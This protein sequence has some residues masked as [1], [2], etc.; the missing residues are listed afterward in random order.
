MDG[1]K[2]IHELV[3]ELAK[4]LK[5]ARLPTTKTS[6]KTDLLNIN[7]PSEN[8]LG[9]CTS[10]IATPSCSTALQDDSALKYC[11]KNTIYHDYIDKPL[12]NVKSLENLHSTHDQLMLSNVNT[13]TIFTCNAQDS[14]LTTLRS[15]SQA[16]YDT[17]NQNPIRLEPDSLLNLLSDDT[18]IYPHS[19]IECPIQQNTLNQTN[20]DNASYQSV[21]LEGVMIR[22][23][24]YIQ[25]PAKYFPMIIGS[26]TY[27]L[28][29]NDNQKT[30]VLCLNVVL[31]AGKYI[32]AKVV[33]CGSFDPNTS[34]PEG[35]NLT[36]EDEIKVLQSD[37][38]I[39]NMTVDEKISIREL[40]V[41]SGDCCTRKITIISLS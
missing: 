12:S 32:V 21:S 2:G 41:G 33:G 27:V 40:E 34:Y 23:P 26:E 28:P 39:S 3:G 5:N 1:P 22:I 8:L 17:G 30:I 37:L 31:A 38:C 10:H 7:E 25:V 24:E 29:Y 15:H 36:F 20:N 11:D 14:T 4:A 19:S 6:E 13:S 18:D 16:S 9:L 35:V